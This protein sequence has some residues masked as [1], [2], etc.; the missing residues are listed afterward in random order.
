MLINFLN[1]SEKRRLQFAEILSR[2]EDW[3][4][5]SE[6]AQQ[7]NYS[8]RTLKDDIVFLKNNFTDFQVQTSHHGVRLIFE[9]NKGLRSLYQKILTESVAYH[10]LEIIF[11][12]EG[13]TIS[14]LADSFFISSSTLYRIINQI[15][16]SIRQYDC[17]IET[18][19][20]RIIGS[21]KNIRYF[22]YQYF[23][24]KHSPLE[25]PYKTIH[26]NSLDKL[27]IFFTD[28]VP[29]PIDFSHYNDFKLV[30]VV[31]LIRYQNNHY[32]D[33]DNFEIN[34]DE[35]IPD[36]SIYADIFQS[37][38]DSLGV[39]FNNDLINQLFTPFVQEGFSLSYERLIEKTR[40]NKTMAAEVSLL[41]KLLDKLS[42]D[43]DIPLVNKER[44]ILE[45]QNTTHLEYQ[46]P[47]SGHILYNNNKY[48]SE[49]IRYKFP[50][51]YNDLYEGMI[52]YR[53]LQDKPITEDGIDF[54]ICSLFTYWK[55]LVPE[56][57]KKFDKIKVLVIS[58]H[59][60]LHAD[61]LKDFI[62]SEFT[63][64]LVVDIYMDN[65]LSLSMLEDLNYDFIVTNFPLPKLESKR[66]IYIENV[67]TVNDLIKIEE[68]VNRIVSVREQQNI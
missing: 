19:P 53:K 37:F 13:K 51:F 34:F 59:H 48:F 46:K 60:I 35:I 1:N 41:I 8:D 3:T 66:N 26:E 64:Q 54:F 40:E 10:F 56:L 7:L 11:M 24:E 68:A 55:N 58:N 42:T 32:V 62:Q 33:T 27:L 36:L 5:L 45:M 52:A 30:T 6:L 16:D 20:C 21:E 61:M 43:N 22:F 2:Q 12:D 15:N 25:W 18:N 50:V 28:F 14:E 17:F 9:H 49:A 65:H 63:E 29:L 67:P 47:Q 38:E 23:F 44:V 57:H 4:L 31:N 39:K